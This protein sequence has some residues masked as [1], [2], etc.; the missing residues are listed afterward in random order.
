[1]DPNIGAIETMYADFKRAYESKNESQVLRFISPDWD[2]GDGTSMSDL[3]G[4]LRNIFT[5][6]NEVRCGITGLR[7]VKRSDGVYKVTYNMAITGRIFD[8]NIKHEEKSSVEEQVTINGSGKP[9][10]S[11]TMKGNFWYFE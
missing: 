5:V 3:S 2:A 9:V 7:V 1:M 10:I 8:Q 4:Y 6:F 11:K